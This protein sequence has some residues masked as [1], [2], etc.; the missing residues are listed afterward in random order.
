MN[1]YKVVIEIDIDKKQ[2]DKQSE[3]QQRLL[4]ADYIYT[5]A[6]GNELDFQI[7]DKNQRSLWH[8]LNYQTNEINN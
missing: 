6:E 3:Y 1:E 4:L 2:F 8:Q 5:L 7:I